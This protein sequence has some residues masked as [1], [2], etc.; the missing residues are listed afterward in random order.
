MKK[1]GPCEPTGPVT[2]LSTR[3]SS[4]P[5]QCRDPAAGERVLRFAPPVKSRRTREKWEWKRRRGRQ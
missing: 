1:P 4:H 2:N 5:A 3:S